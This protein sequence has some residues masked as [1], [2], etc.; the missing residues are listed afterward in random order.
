MR[1]ERRGRDGWFMSLEG[2]AQCTE[3]NLGARWGQEKVS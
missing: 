3:R 1:F 2:V